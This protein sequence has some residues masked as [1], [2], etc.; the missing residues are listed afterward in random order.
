MLSNND[1]LSHLERSCP[2]EVYRVEEW[3]DPR[4]CKHAGYEEAKGGR[5]R[6]DYRCD[7]AAGAARSLR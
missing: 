6:D 3:I 4:E 5:W 2:G 1:L 7:A